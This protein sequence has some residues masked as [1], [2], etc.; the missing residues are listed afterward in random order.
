M[1]FSENEK[2]LC[3]CI[4]FYRYCSFTA[5]TF[6]KY[7][8]ELHTC[9][10]SSSSSCHTW[11][12]MC[13]ARSWKRAIRLCDNERLHSNNVDVGLANVLEKR[14]RYCLRKIDGEKIKNRYG[15]KRNC[16][17]SIGYAT[18]V[19]SS[20]RNTHDR[21]L[22]FISATLTVH[23]F[24]SPCTTFHWAKV[25]LRCLESVRE[26]EQERGTTE[27]Q[28]YIEIHVVLMAATSTTTMTMA[29]FNFAS[30]SCLEHFRRR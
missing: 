12:C 9:S 23:F 19:F 21:C 24:S 28:R 22:N 16:L 26:R 18:W 1:A 17:F 27:Q 7:F 14:A 20:Y 25:L 5:S 30:S 6:R 8:C 29:S 11:L 15:V 2:S 10:G 13:V 4:V 3:F